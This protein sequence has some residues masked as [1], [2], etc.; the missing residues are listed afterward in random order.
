MRGVTASNVERSHGDED[1]T[2]LLALSDGLFAIV[3]TLLVLDLRPSDSSALF[4]YPQLVALWP[5]LF[6]FFLTFY[7][8][9]SFWVAHHTDF[10]RIA[11]YDQRLLW[12]NLMFLLPVSL[13][14]FTT[15]LIGDHTN[16]VTW[17]LYALNMIGVGLGL[18][19]VWGYANAAGMT[20]SRVSPEYRRIAT[21]R[22]FV[23][24]AVFVISIP[25][26]VFTHLAPF[27]PLLLPVASRLF[28]RIVG[29]VPTPGR[30]AGHWGWVVLGYVL[31]LAFAAWSIWLLLKGEL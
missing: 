4:A 16:S 8:G 21:L 9:G 1:Q 28:S 27:V 5:K 15:A 18:A 30:R 11:G 29:D 25:F 12:L 19:A 3:L 13:L 6:G 10:D 24:P 22:H 14:P 26:A 20:R 17:I 31:P 7:V 23:V 2:R